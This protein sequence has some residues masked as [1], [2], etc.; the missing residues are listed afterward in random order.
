[1][2]D[3]ILIEK[4]GKKSSVVINLEFTNKNLANNMPELY[5]YYKLRVATTSTGGW[6]KGFEYTKNEKYNILPALV[7]LGWV[8][9]D[10]KKINKYRSVVANSGC[11][12]RVSVEI[13]GFELA[14]LETFKG[15]I[16]ATNEK[17]L[18]DKK[19][20]FN[21]QISDCLAKGKTIPSSWSKLKGA[22]QVVLATK[23]TKDGDVT[24][25][26]GRA[27]NEELSRLMGLG[28]ATITR[29]RAKSKD[30]GFNSY[31]LRNIRVNMNHISKATKMVAEDRRAKGSIYTARDNKSA[32]FT[33]DLLITSGIKLF[34]VS[35]S[36]RNSKKQER[37]KLINKI[38]KKN[39]KLV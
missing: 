34:S 1:M 11:K 15:F 35:C 2:E 31:E 14:D 36:N 16:L 21:K 32:I 25:V 6:I 20:R 39:V 12:S 37:E 33:K 28:T 10:L 3:F 9:E 5:L 38:I 8:T 7:K 18:L 23:K 30:N 27:F 4:V 17:Y 22:A 26:T 13:S 24:T 29:W 19:E